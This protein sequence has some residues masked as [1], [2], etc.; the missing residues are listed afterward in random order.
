MYSKRQNSPV[1]NLI[2]EYLAVVDKSVYNRF[3]SL[4]GNLDQSV[5]TLYIKNFFSVLVNGIC[6]N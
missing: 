4:Y 5:I 3:V 2:V 1:N 6:S